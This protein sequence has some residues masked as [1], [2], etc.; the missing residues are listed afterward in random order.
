MAAFAYLDEAL[1]PFDCCG[2]A[3]L[4]R[5][6]FLAHLLF[7]CLLLLAQ[8]S[9]ALVEM[10]LAKTHHVPLHANQLVCLHPSLNFRL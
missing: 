1:R 7:F 5:S 4:R 8:I 10:G 2:V 3:L 6:Y 9:V